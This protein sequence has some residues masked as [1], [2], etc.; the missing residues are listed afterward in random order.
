MAIFDRLDR[1]TSRQVDRMYS[2]RATVDPMS[3]TPN[4]RAAPDT[5]RGT[6]HL[7]GIFDQ[8]PAYDGIEVGK[9]ERSGNDLH[10]ISTGSSYSFSFDVGRYP[11]LNDIRQGDRLTLDDA[12]KFEVV[13]VERDGLSRA[14]ARLTRFEG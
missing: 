6:I 10:T 2:V 14:V 9:R 13:S 5:T 12:R 1:M 4:G 11:I 8:L 7:K 3:R